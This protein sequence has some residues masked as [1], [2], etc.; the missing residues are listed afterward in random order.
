[1][2]FLAWILVWSC[3]SE[4]QLN[5]GIHDKSQVEK[6]YLLPVSSSMVKFIIWDGDGKHILNQELVIGYTREPCIFHLG[7]TLN[8]RVKLY[9]HEKSQGG[10]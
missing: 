1:M 4:V 5:T 2:K 9:I 3:M 6:A 10:N 7:C 8:S